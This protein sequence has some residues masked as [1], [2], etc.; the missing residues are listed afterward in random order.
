MSGPLVKST[1]EWGRS[2]GEIGPDGKFRCK[3][4]NKLLEVKW[5]WRT[6]GAESDFPFNGLEVKR[7]GHVYCPK[8]TPKPQ[9]PEYGTQI[10]L[11]DLE[12]YQP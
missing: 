8:C 11:N 12:G 5:I 1:A 7:V 3:K 9:F 2:H 6:I 10:A 4:T